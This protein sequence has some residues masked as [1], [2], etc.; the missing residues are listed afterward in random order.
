KGFSVWTL[1]IWNCKD[2]APGGERGTGLRPRR[3]APHRLA[4][5]RS[6]GHLLRV[7]GTV[8]RGSHLVLCAARVVGLLLRPSHAAVL[9]SMAALAGTCGPGL[10]GRAGLLL[11]GAAVKGIGRLRRP[12]NAIL[13]CRRQ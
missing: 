12:I 11:P 2:G 6:H 7:A 8:S 3:R 10:G 9:G 4:A 1:V 13:C 5:E